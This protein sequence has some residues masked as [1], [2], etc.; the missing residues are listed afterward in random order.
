MQSPPNIYPAR[1]LLPA[2]TCFLATSV[3]SVSGAAFR[4]A[5]GSEFE[6]LKWT[7]AALNWASV[8]V[9]AG[10]FGRRGEGDEGLWSEAA[11]GQWAGSVRGGVRHCSASRPLGSQLLRFTAGLNQAYFPKFVVV[12]GLSV[13][14]I[15]I[16]MLPVS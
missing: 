9:C 2:N 3:G 4:S 10:G 6:P 12:L 16:L 13:A 11:C 8:G 14:V 5:K 7:A 1:H 15:S